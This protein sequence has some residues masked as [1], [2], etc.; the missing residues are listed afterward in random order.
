MT[1]DAQLKAF[2]KFLSFVLRHEP[3]SIGLSLDE[4]GWASVDD[5]L[6]KAAAAGKRLDRQ[7]LQRVVDTSDKKRF[8]FSDDGQR[9]RANQGHSIDV[10]LGLKPALP[11]ASLYHGTASRFL[12]S[13]LLTGLDKRERHHVHLTEDLSIARSVGQRYGKVVLLEVDAGRM[14]NDGHLFFRSDNAVWLTDVVPP[15]YIRVLT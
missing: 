9:I 1:Q 4:A 13:I 5:L 14:H 7:L 8:A 12:D 15:A 11:P 10:S 3:Q 2:S 6:V